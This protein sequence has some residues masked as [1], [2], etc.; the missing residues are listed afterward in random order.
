ML[1]GSVDALD[2]FYDAN[3]F[4]DY[5]DN[6]DEDRI[7]LNEVLDYSNRLLDSVCEISLTEPMDQPDIRYVLAHHG[8]VHKARQSEASNRPLMEVY[9][10]ITPTQA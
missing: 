1:I 3:P 4:P 5:Y 10:A 2:A 7:S 8:M 6:P 9:D